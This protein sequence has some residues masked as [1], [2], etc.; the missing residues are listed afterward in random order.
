MS[1]EGLC[2]RRV[3]SAGG[4]WR[5]PTHEVQFGLLDLE[6]AVDRRPFL[7]G[8]GLGRR[9]RARVQRRQQL[10]Q[11]GERVLGIH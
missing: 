3:S 7:F 8:Q 1:W 9:S 10:L 11:V 5:S 2:K 4:I 6:K